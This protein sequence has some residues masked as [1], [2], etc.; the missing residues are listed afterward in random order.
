MKGGINLYGYVGADPVNWVDPWGLKIIGTWLKPELTSKILVDIYFNQFQPAF[1]VSP[2]PIGG[3]IFGYLPVELYASF[4]LKASCYDDCTDERWIATYD[5]E[6][7]RLPINIPIYFNPYKL[8]QKAVNMI[9]MAANNQ[10]KIN[11]LGQKAKD[12]YGASA[13]TLCELKKK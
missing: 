1:D 9:R 2:N 7:V 10:D 12:K 8:W 5:I 13:G 11:Q 3:T 6:E 4:K